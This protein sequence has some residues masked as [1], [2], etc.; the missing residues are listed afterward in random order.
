MI[1][2]ARRAPA[3]RWRRRSAP[4]AIIW[5]AARR[6][7]PGREP[8]PL[9]IVR[10]DGIK[11]F[12]WRER[13]CRRGHRNIGYELIEADRK[14]VFQPPNPQLAQVEQA[15]LADAR[16]RYAWFATTRHRPRK[17]RQPR[18]RPVYRA[19]R[20]GGIDRE[21][22][23]SLA[24][25]DG[26]ST[27]LR[28]RH[29]ADSALPAA[30]SA[31]AETGK[32][33]RPGGTAADMAAGGTGSGSAAGRQR[34]RRHWDRQRFRNG[35][36]GGGDSGRTAVR[37]RNRQR[38][39]RRRGSAMAARTR[40]A[41]AC[42]ATA[43]GQRLWRLDLAARSGS[44]Y[45]TA[46]IGLR[47]WRFRLW[48]GGN[49]RRSP[50]ATAQRIRRSEPALA[51]L[52]APGNGL[53]GAAESRI[54]RQRLYRLAR[55]R[56]IKAAPVS[57]MGPAAPVGGP[58]VPAESPADRL[59]HGT[60]IA[61]SGIGG[62]GSGTVG[63]RLPGGQHWLPA[64]RKLRPGVNGTGGTAAMATGRRAAASGDRRRQFVRRLV[65]S[66][67]QN[68]GYSGVPGPGG[69]I[70]R[71]S[72][73]GSNGDAGGNLPAVKAA[74]PA[75]RHRGADARRS[76]L[77]A[78]AGLADRQCHARSGRRPSGSPSASD[79]GDGSSSSGMPSMMMSNNPPPPTVQ[80]PT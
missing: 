79:G 78:A 73:S 7:T 23:A 11:L 49:G 4:R 17:N 55:Q 43:A 31:A 76:K 77:D 29:I 3:I 18:E 71:G 8:Y 57:G 47:N 41:D 80:T 60:G 15:A 74:R 25:A 65:P 66:G 42:A 63:R 22:E 16:Q 50:A 21:G 35:G 56:R 69:T 54:R 9:L 5:P 27:R 28:Q 12:I 40:Q 2:K 39:R 32:W 70:R 20:T 33:I 62:A 30:D 19:S 68:T 44:G 34:Q 24:D 58:A 26:A 52:A 59:A 14:L 67:T 48:T 36:T 46:W 51:R 1:S 13:R 61:G 53:A 75:A 64:A 6:P 38:H 72:L 37:Q 10:S 45:G